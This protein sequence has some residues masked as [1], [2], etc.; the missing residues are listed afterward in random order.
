MCL[1]N[2]LTDLSLHG[3][4]TSNNVG[5]VLRRCGPQKPGNLLSIFE[6]CNQCVILSELYYTRTAP[7]LNKVQLPLSYELVITWI[8]SV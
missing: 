5:R 8:K 3:N 2:I 6:K 1:A 4:I 7:L